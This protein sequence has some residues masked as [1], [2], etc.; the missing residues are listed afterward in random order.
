MRVS[1]TLERLT[2]PSNFT[3]YNASVLRFYEVCDVEGFSLEA[4]LF[5]IWRETLYV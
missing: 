2:D 1:D 4:F 5:E 3:S